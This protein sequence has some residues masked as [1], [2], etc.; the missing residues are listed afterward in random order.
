MRIAHPTSAGEA[1]GTSMDVDESQ[2]SLYRALVDRCQSLEASHSRLREQLDELVQEIKTNKEEREMEVGIEEVGLD[3]W[4][5]GFPG[6]FVDGS[7]YRRALECMGHAV[8]VC[9]ASSGEILYWNH[10]AE[11]LY[12]WKEYEVLGQQVAEVLVDEEYYEPLQKI[13]D[14]L[15][16]TG[17]SWSGQFPYKKR[18]GEIFMAI[19]T[20]SH[21][22]EDGVLAGFITVSSDAALFNSII[23]SENPRTRDQDR[24]GQDRHQPA[25][26]LQG[27]NLKGIQWPQNFYCGGMEI[28]RTAVHVTRLCTRTRTLHETL[29]AAKVLAKLRIKGTGKRG[30]EDDGVIQENDATDS[31]EIAS[32]HYSTRGTEGTYSNVYY[33]GHRTSPNEFEDQTSLHV[34]AL[35]ECTECFRLPRPGDPLPRIGCQVDA[36]EME[37]QVSN[38]KASEIED[39]MQEQKDDKRLPSSA[40]T[41]GSDG[42]S[43]SKGEN[44]SNSLVDC[45][46]RWEDLYFGD[47]IGQGSYAIV[48]RGIWNGSDV[49][50]KV[51]LGN[52]Y[53]EGTLQDYMKEIDIMKRLRHPNVLLFMGAVYTQERLAIVTEFLPRGSLFRTLHKNSQALDIRRRLRMA[54][55][56]A[57]GMNYLHHRHPPIVHRDLKSSNLL[58]D[59]NWTVKVGDFGLSRLKNST[60]LTARSGRGTPQ[61]MAPEVLRNEPS[62][63]K[64]DVFSFGV[65]LWELMTESIPWNNLNSLQ[66]VGVVGFMDRRLDLPQGLDP[67]IAFIIQDC[68]QRYVRT[69]PE[70]RPSFQD[71]IQRMTALIASTAA[72]STRRSST[73]ET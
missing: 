69:N 7:P 36:K 65:I 19:V 4:C 67:P 13:M 50:I 17:Q 5:G 45:E 64:S 54:L 58:V 8:H 39:E 38:L 68:W 48:Y 55:D 33:N 27:L 70:Q 18:S 32:C 49:A 41:M 37:L 14:S 23:C 12:G 52:E 24:A 26:V 11:R 10:S 35:G 3:S 30:E 25:R 53:S 72:V 43:S 61:W 9:R 16:S 60:F 57:R 34:A 6:F 31:T 28:I 62:N 21:L 46:I 51:Y 15:S 1:P 73:T 40:E 20:K 63:E 29:K 44:E 42:S 47:E 71:V 66:V 56:V 22:Y 2:T 59:K